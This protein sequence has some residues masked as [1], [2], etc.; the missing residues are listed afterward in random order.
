MNTW[1]KQTNSSNKRTEPGIAVR[2]N[3]LALNVALVDAANVMIGDYAEV[4][5][6]D[7]GKKIGIKFF[8][9]KKSDRFRVTQDGGNLSRCNDL[10]RANALISCGK[11]VK[12][13]NLNELVGSTNA[14]IVVSKEEGGIW[15][16][17]ISNRWEYSVSERDPKDDEIGV[18]RYLSDGEVVYI[19]MGRIKQRIKENWRHHWLYDS[20]E[21]MLLDESEARREEGRL[22][23][24][25]RDTLG[26]LPIYN[27]ILG[28]KK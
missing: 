13:S 19:G 22:L 12:S 7:C 15:V 17:Q 18:Y 14:K 9:E 3:G 4:Y 28:S 24:G 26:R 23:S 10:S 11:I 27:R 2:R 25:H 5:I 8:K 1:V 16:A 21:Y 20:I 6:S